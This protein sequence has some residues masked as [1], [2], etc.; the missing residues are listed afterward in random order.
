[1]TDLLKTAVC[2]YS[3]LCYFYIFHSKKKKKKISKF[4]QTKMLQEGYK[5]MMS[6]FLVHNLKKNNLRNL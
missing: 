2:D 4:R 6:I 1:M 5:M 3:L